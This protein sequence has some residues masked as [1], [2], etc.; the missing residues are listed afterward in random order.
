MLRGDDRLALVPVSGAEDDGL[1][2]LATAAAVLKLGRSIAAGSKTLPGH[3]GGWY[4]RASE[5]TRS[6][7]GEPNSKAASVEDGELSNERAGVLERAPEDSTK[8]GTGDAGCP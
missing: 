4:W 6:G 7:N 5:Q 1:S 3:G 2:S 8:E